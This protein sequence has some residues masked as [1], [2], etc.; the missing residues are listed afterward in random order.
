[1]QILLIIL[2][3]RVKLRLGFVVSFRSLLGPTTTTSTIHLNYTSS[4]LKEGPCLYQTYCRN[5]YF[6][7][8]LIMTIN[9]GYQ[10]LNTALVCSAP[11]WSK[12]LTAFVLSV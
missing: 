12:Q 3:K 9:N 5:Q 6:R 4:Q 7:S 1:M 10:S 2:T 8:W 11:W